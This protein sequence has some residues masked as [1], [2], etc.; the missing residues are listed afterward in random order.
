MQKI[1][2]ERRMLKLSAENWYWVQKVKVKCKNLKFNQQIDSSVAS[3]KRQTVAD[4]S[5][6]SWTT[7]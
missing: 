1:E 5:G 2:I 4:S 3:A 6:E 7:F